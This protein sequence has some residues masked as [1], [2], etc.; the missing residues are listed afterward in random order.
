M[1][2]EN[3][4]T[5]SSFNNGTGGMKRQRGFLTSKQAFV[6]LAL[7]FLAPS[8]VA[9]VMHKTGDEGWRPEGTTNRGK[10]VHPARPLEMPASLK[11]G[12]VALNDYLKGKWTL[13]YIGGNACDEACNG[14]LYKMRQ[15]RTAQ[16]ENMR[17]V[18]KLY[19]VLD[20]TLPAELASMLEEHY[21]VLDVLPLAAADRSAI[22]PYFDIDGKGMAGAER[23]YFIDPLGNLMMYYPADADPS[24][25]LKDLK[26][27]LKY[28]KFG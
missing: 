25:M 15:I 20:E 13:L 19:L 27:L 21:P 5:S 10:L 14:N 11:I 9:F 3:T 6:V 28:S 16:N 17:R 4:M 18:Q 24:G 12:D 26:K 8:F 1:Q 23:V 2:T 22:A 7:I